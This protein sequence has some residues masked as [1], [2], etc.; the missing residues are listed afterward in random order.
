MAITQISRIKV[1]TGDNADLPVLDAGEFGYSTDTEQLYIGNVGATLPS[2]NTEILTAS[3]SIPAPGSSGELI[4]NNIG[5]LGSIS[6]V[7]YNG[8]VI[9]L[10]NESQVSITG[11]SAGNVLT[12][13]GSGNLSWSVGG[14]GA[15]GYSGAGGPAGA[16]GYSGAAGTAGTSGYSGIAGTAGTSGYSGINGAS[17]YSGIAGFSG[18]SGSGGNLIITDD[19]STNA[20]RYLLF[21]DAT[22]GTIASSNVSS[23]KLYF[24]PNTGIV[25]ASN[26]NSLSDLKFKENIYTIQD[27][28]DAVNKLRGVGFTWKDNGNKSYGVI[29]QELGEIL[30][31][32]IS[33]NSDSSL[34]VNYMGLIGFLINAVKELDTRLKQVE[35][36]K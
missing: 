12:T 26:F 32:L 2:D 17:G 29:A 27:A 8:S 28:V 35:T 1:R 4:Y 15:S 9:T 21:T 5:Y 7:T 24:N 19:T 16:S 20:T 6:S 18:Y 34:S 25:S 3:S 10:G 22:T 33:A 23:T 36:N 31:E 13:D 30:P 11:G 14:G